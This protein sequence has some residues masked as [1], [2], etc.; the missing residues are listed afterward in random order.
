MQ[1]TEESEIFNEAP[2]IKELKFVQKV[3]KEL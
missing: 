1:S 2:I 3:I